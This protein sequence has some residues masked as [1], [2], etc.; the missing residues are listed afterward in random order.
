MNGEMYPHQRPNP[1][2]KT[3]LTLAVIV[4][5]V[6]GSVGGMMTGI[7]ASSTF[8]KKSG[9]NTVAT[10]NTQ[11]ST[12]STQ[13]VVQEESDTTQVVSDAEK[14]IVSVII[15]KD[16]SKVQQ[17][18]NFFGDPF[19]QDNSSIDT[20]NS[21]QPV[22]ICSGTGFVISED[23]MILTNKHVICDDSASYSVVFSDGTTHD[24][25]VVDTDPLSDLAILKI[26]ATGLT[27]VKLGDS[28]ALTQGQTVIA[29][30]NALG[31]FQNTVT[32]GVISG[33]NRDLGGNYTDL[34]QTDA[35]INEGNSGGPLIDLAGE[36]IGINTAIRRDSNAEGLGFAIP[37]NEAKV[38]I[39]SV[40]SS[41]HI[42]RPALGVRY[43][44]I[45]E[46]FAKANNLPYTYGAYIHSSDPKNPAVIPGGSADKAGITDGSIILE[47]D[48]V[49][50]DDTH[51]LAST[52]KS[53][54][55]GDELTLKVY[56]GTSEK[57][58]QVTLIELPS[59]S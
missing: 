37:I 28:A 42:V 24:A 54:T 2:A 14:S 29:I 46:A 45:N 3:M 25:T 4:S 17:Q 43:Q 33:L 20:N 36:V 49:K 19:A 35:A 52:I 39:D 58:V 26:D 57:D 41:G 30:G 55:L 38:A 50:V 44:P 51:P 31:E 34:I 53:H 59:N 9:V 13:R 12:A 32:K 48:G 27:P 16:L 7:V 56:D 8:L 6:A 47:V 11:N 18:Q 1:S 21:D 5:F 10:A 15:S 22:E 23:G 40:K